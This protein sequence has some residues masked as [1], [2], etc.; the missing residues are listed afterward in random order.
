MARLA[1]AV[2]LVQHVLRAQPVRVAGRALEMVVGLETEGIRLP[3]A[4]EE[5]H[6]LGRALGH[7]QDPVGDV[8]LAAAVDL[9]RAPL[10]LH[11][12][13]ARE[14]DAE[15]ARLG[16]VDHR[17]VELDRDPRTLRGDQLIQLDG[18]AHH[19]VVEEHDAHRPIEPLEHGGGGFGERVRPGAGEVEP[20]R[21]AY[22]EIGDREQDADDPQRE[23]R[24]LGPA[25]MGE[26]GEPVPQPD[27]A[28]RREQGPGARE[29]PRGGDGLEEDRVHHEGGRE[30]R[31][32]REEDQPRADRAVPS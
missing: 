24:D 17:I 15:H 25:A 12:R 29:D 5:A 26:G 20:E 21:I 6:P 27:R 7:A 1:E 28:D 18:L 11:D 16:R 4:V 22:R 2:T 31:D 30:Q 9:E 23:E 13:G 3:V 32:P 14:V 19:R 10:A 8:G